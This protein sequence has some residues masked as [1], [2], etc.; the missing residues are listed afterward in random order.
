MPPAAPASRLKGRI[1]AL[2]FTVLLSG[3]TGF[4]GGAYVANKPTAAGGSAEKATPDATKAKAE[5]DARKTSND[6]RMCSFFLASTKG[7][8]FT[9]DRRKIIDEAVKPLDGTGFEKCMVTLREELDEQ[10]KALPDDDRARLF[11]VYNPLWRLAE[12][13]KKIMAIDYTSPGA[14]ARLIAWEV[15]T[16]RIFWAEKKE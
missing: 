1:L 9:A 7:Q 10:A 2:L 12:L 16:D 11:R 5:F 6:A 14:E 13:R 3:G 8:K 4:L 15:E